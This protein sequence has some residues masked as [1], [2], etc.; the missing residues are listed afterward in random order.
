VTDTWLDW[1]PLW[2]AHPKPQLT[3]LTLGLLRAFNLVPVRRAEKI[4][5]MPCGHTFH[6]PQR[7]R[8]IS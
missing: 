6:F 1:Q 2:D 7:I 8:R 5:N 3:R 4:A